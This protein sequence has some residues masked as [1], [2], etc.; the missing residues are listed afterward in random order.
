MSRHALC[1]PAPP[2]GAGVSSTARARDRLYHQQPHSG[3]GVASFISLK[4]LASTTM[5]LLH[6]PSST[7]QGACVTPPGTLETVGKKRSRTPNVIC[8]P[9]YSSGAYHLAVPYKWKHSKGKENKKITRV[10]FQRGT[11]FQAFTWKMLI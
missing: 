1:T 2:P 3:P 6:Q 7:A 10:T 4:R 11:T 9:P 5:A 8:R